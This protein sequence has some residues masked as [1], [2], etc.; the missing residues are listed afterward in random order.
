MFAEH[1][2]QRVPKAF[3]LSFYLRERSKLFTLQRAV[4]NVSWLLQPATL[5]SMNYARLLRLFSGSDP[6]VSLPGPRKAGPTFPHGLSSIFPSL[7]LPLSLSPPALIFTQQVKVRRQF[8]K[9]KNYWI[10]WSSVTLR[11]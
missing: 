9:L 11:G 8:L 6:F 10:L 4:N 3:L 1:F 5:T 2:I 7:L